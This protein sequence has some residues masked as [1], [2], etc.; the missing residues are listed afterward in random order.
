MPLARA[1][2][3]FAVLLLPW[4][5]IGYVLLRRAGGEVLALLAAFIVVSVA[6]E[7]SLRIPAV[8]RWRERQAERKQASVVLAGAHG[9]VIGASAGRLLR[10]AFGR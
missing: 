2:V 10:R 6:S 8:R 3:G 1:L 5:L 4:V 9:R 7:L